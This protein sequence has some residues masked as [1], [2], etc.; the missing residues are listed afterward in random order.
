MI[1]Q[2]LVADAIEFVCGDSRRD[3]AA[4]LGKGLGA[5]MKSLDGIPA[6]ARAA[7]E[8]RTP[9]IF[10]LKNWK[11]PRNDFAEYMEKRKPG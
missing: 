11:A 8:K 9:E 6:G 5:K 10:D 3:I 7:L 4:D 2:K 1:A